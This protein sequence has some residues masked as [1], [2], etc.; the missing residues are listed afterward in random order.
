MSGE[1]EQSGDIKPTASSS[2]STTD[3]ISVSTS[4]SVS[5]ETGISPVVEPDESSVLKKELD[6]LKKDQAEINLEVKR[7]GSQLRKIEG[8]IDDIRK[9][10][11]LIFGLFASLLA[12]LAIE[13]QV[14]NHIKTFSDVMGVNAFLLASFILFAFMM[15]KIFKASERFVWSDLVILLIVL[16]LL[17]AS[18]ECFLYGTHNHLIWP[19]E[20]FAQRT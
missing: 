13:V 16:L 3:S 17:Y 4:P 11:I 5:I 2:I 19:L 1:N 8:N 10:F 7:S 12:F 9:D 14:F 20:R 15:G 18:T 6:Q